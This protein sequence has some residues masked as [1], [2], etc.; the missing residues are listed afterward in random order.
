VAHSL[1][2]VIQIH[3]AGW[4]RVAELHAAGC[5]PRVFTYTW[6][7]GHVYLNTRGKMC[8]WLHHDL[9]RAKHASTCMR[10]MVRHVYSVRTRG[11]LHVA[12][13]Y[14]FCSEKSEVESCLEGTLS[15]L[16][17]LVGLNGFGSCSCLLYFLFCSF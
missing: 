15:D 3:V 4:T 17:W 9:T 16:I 6:P 12:I 5:L 14:F 2:R 11:E 7:Y 8:I 1:P 13:C 10:L